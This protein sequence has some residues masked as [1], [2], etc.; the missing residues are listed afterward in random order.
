MV[1]GESVRFV[2]DFA[3]LFVEGEPRDVDWTSRLGEKEHR[4]P[5]AR[6]VAVDSYIQRLRRFVFERLALCTVENAKYFLSL[7]H[8]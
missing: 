4:K 8:I 1:G 2:D 3:D 6:P 7:I 5:D